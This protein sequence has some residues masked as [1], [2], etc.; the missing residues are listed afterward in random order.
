MNQ[1]S[2]NINQSPSDL[3][4]IRRSLSMFEGVPFADIVKP[5]LSTG[6]IAVIVRALPR[7]RSNMLAATRAQIETL[8]KVLD[9][10]L[11]ECQS[12]GELHTHINYYADDVIAVRD[13]LEKSIRGVP[14]FTPK[15]R[16]THAV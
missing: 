1:N 5:R 7:H 14:E 15:Q 16:E 12:A 6:K 9:A 4:I 8:V 10:V 2:F 13:K 11:A 3:D